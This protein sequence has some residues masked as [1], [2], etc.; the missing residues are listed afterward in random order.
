MMA[1]LFVTVFTI[2]ASD[3]YYYQSQFAACVDTFKMGLNNNAGFEKILKSLD[4][5]QSGL[6]SETAIAKKEPL[7][8]DIKSV[9]SLVGEISPSPKS[10]GL[11][12]DQKKRASKIL[13]ISE[14]L[15]ND[16]IFCLP[17]TEVKLWDSTYTCYMIDN[18][19]DSMMTVYKI[20]FMVQKKYSSYTGVVDAGVSKKSSRGIF[21]SFGDIKNVKFSK[22]KC[23]E[24]LQM[25][26]YIQPEVVQPKVEKYPEPDYLSP[27][28]KQ[29][30]KKK[31]KEQLQ[32]DKEKSKK[33]ALKDKDTKKKE[34]DKERKDA[35]NSELKAREEKAKELSD[36]KKEK[37]SGGSKK[38]TTTNKNSK[39]KNTKKSTTKVKA[40]TIQKSSTSKANTKS[41][42]K[43]KNQPATT[44]VK[45]KTE[46]AA[47]KVNTTDKTK[48]TT[49]AKIDAGQK[50]S[51]VAGKAKDAVVTKAT[52]TT[53][54]KAKLAP[55]KTNVTPKDAAV[56][57][58]TKDAKNIGTKKPVTPVKNDTIKKAA[59][60][61]AVKTVAKVDSVKANAV[62]KVT[63]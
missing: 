5:L 26:K 18:K 43:T 31:E 19:S 25:T 37:T 20:K 28:Q 21:K 38:A 8:S 55:A 22:E 33:Q 6:S 39:D 52:T 51:V 13:G 57:D 63:K 4:Q 59:T 44:T 61:T 3:I 17:I 42:D 29:A 34:Q 47:P 14:K 9:Y 41:V 30:L 16:T 24:Q 49:Q 35:K 23:E 32:K 54:D 2:Q 27:Q 7:L 11:T 36:A 60:K 12:L 10:Y 62:Q 58:K 40:D 50:S 48:P 46:V 15:Y 53:T 1:A 56:A 45:T